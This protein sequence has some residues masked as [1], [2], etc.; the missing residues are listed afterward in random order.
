MEFSNKRAYPIIGEI[1]LL[2][3]K[4]PYEIFFGPD[5]ITAWTSKCLNISLNVSR[6][7][8]AI[9]LAT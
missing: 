1:M 3:R 9:V 6:R 2:L 8:I 4:F 7:I 5:P